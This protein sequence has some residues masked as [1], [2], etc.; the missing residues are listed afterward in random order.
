MRSVDNI[1]Y[2]STNIGYENGCAQ[3]VVLLLVYKR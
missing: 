1:R 3:V 2:Q